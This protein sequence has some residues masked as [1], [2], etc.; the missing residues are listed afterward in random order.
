M[1]LKIK[2]WTEK[3]VKAIF[4]LILLTSLFS[5]LEYASAT[6]TSP[7]IV[8]VSNSTFVGG[9]TNRSQDVKG[10]ITTLTLSANQ[11]DYKWKAYVGNVSGSFTLDD[12]NA[13]TIYNWN[14]GTAT[15]EVYVS[16]ASSINWVNVSCVNQSVID[17]EEAAFGTSSGQ[18]DSINKTFNYTIHK[19]FL[20]GTKNISNSTCR[21]TATYINDAAQSIT[22]SA[23]FQEL[24]LKDDISSSLIYTTIIE[25]HH[26]GYDG[27]N[28]FD[29]QLLVAENESATAPTMYYFYV[30][31]G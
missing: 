5:T 9:V 11:Q 24:L 30:E 13:K 12:A 16:R 7:S 3:I 28:N 23:F 1:I 10:T 26:L 27:A 29:F 21:S 6:P 14:E 15:G 17:N 22:E 18:V 31:L 20:V 2:N 19:S 8:Y 25:Q 4:V